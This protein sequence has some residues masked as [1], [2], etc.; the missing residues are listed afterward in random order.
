M[1]KPCGWGKRG[2]SARAPA[3]C[4]SGSSDGKRGSGSLQDQGRRGR[5]NKLVRAD[6]EG[7]SERP[8]QQ[9]RELRTAWEEKQFEL[10]F[11]PQVSL[12]T[13]K[14]MGAEALLRWNHPVRGLM[15]PAAFLST[16]EKSSLAAPVGQWI[17]EEA[18][19]QAVNW[20]AISPGF[21]MGVNLFSAQFRTAPLYDGVQSAL[22]ATGFA[23][24]QLE[25]EITENI[26]LDDAGCHKEQLQ[27]LHD[28]GVGLA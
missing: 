7:R 21:M 6:A 17:L 25:L 11:Q 16:L 19:R 24:S 13:R 20:S 23:A 1:G 28:M 27:R 18:C 12:K 3:W 4:G 14:V 15:S 22:E 9:E 10:Y 2:Y 5:P 8:P 26:M